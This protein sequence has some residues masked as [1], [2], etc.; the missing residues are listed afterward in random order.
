M[1]VKVWKLLLQSIFP[2]STLVPPQGQLVP[3]PR[4]GRVRGW[5][6]FHPFFPPR[7][8]HPACTSDWLQWRQFTPAVSPLEQVGGRKGFNISSVLSLRLWGSLSSVVFQ[9]VR[10]ISQ[11]CHS[12]CE[13]HYPLL[14]L[15]LWGSLSSVVTQIVRFIIQCWHSNCEVHYQVFSLILCVSLSSV[16][17]QIMRL[18]F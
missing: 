2:R 15:R 9:I 6:Y 10:F 11:C 16:V 17:T 14:S 3:H 13:V 8:N 4:G 7:V 18:I 12:D 5:H 1:T